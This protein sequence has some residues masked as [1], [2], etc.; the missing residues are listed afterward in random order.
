MKKEKMLNRLTGLIDHGMDAA[1]TVANDLEQRFRNEAR[2]ITRRAKDGLMD[3]TN[4]I[5]SAEEMMMRNVKDHPV[6]YI[7]AG[8]SIFGLLLAFTKLFFD[9]RRHRERW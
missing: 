9:Q 5:V 6:I 2:T 8:L 4:R 7:L 3:Q 1:H